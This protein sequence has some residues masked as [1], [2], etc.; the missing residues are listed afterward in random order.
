MTACEIATR[1]LVHDGR[2]SY[3]VECRPHH[4]EE[5]K[6]TQ[7]EIEKQIEHHGWVVQ[8]NDDMLRAAGLPPQ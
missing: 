3:L 2:L 5:V 8:N 1:P 4:W 7:G 6:D